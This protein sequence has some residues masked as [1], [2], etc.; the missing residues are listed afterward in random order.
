MRFV[1]LPRGQAAAKGSR[2]VC[3][4]SWN[5]WDDFSY[6]TTYEVT[7]YDAAGVEHVLGSAKIMFMGQEPGHQPFD[8]PVEGLPYRFCSLGSDRSYYVAL[9]RLSPALLRPLL[10]GLGDCVADPDRFHGFR[11]EPA[12]TNSLLRGVSPDDVLVSFPRVLG[13]QVQLTPFLFTF[14]LG[15]ELQAHPADG[16]DNMWIAPTASGPPAVPGEVRLGFAV[17]PNSKPPSNV[18][19]LIGRNGVGKTRLLAGMADALTNRPAASFGL[20]GRFEFAVQPGVL[21][22]D[23]LNLVIVSF[24]A[25]DH[26]DPLTGNASARTESSVPL[27]YVGVK[28][29]VGSETAGPPQLGIK[30]PED[31]NSDFGQAIDNLSQDSMRLERWLA[32]MRVLSSDPGIADLD[33][34][35]LPEKPDDVAIGALKARASR[36]SSGHKIVLLT[37]ARLVENVSERSLVLIDEPETHLH[38]PLLGSFMR[39]LSDLLSETNG[40]AIVAT[41]SPVV[42]Q[43]VPRDAVWQLSPADEGLKAE[44]PIAETFAE[45]VSVLTRKVFGLETEQSGFF[46]LLRHEAE[47]ASYDDVDAAF[48]GRIGAEGRALLRAFTWREEPK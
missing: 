23:F 12:M 24:S 18:H 21:Q 42:L 1:K 13:G 31:L 25:F 3:Y 40:V 16:F 15:G 10:A 17:R 27:Y 47:H 9:S 11:N 8:V 30:S 45:N 5:N 39:A 28:K 29:L 14:V 22:T 33:L 26:F 46:R 41:H 20:T 43:E 37:M 4:L 32:A 36:M 48:R 44:R 19:V 2:D 7:V 38:P 34:Q 6:K 35:S